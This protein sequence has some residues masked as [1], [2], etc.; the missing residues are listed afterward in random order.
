MT[1]MMTGIK[2]HTL[3]KS[4]IMAGLGLSL[5]FGAFSLSARQ[6]RAGDTQSNVE[7][8][9]GPQQD[10]QTQPRQGQRGNDQTM[11]EDQQQ[12]PETQAPP[13]QGPPP[14][15]LTLPA[16]TVIRMRLDEWLS[17]DRNVI[18]DDFGATLDQPIVVDGWVVARRGQSE[19]GRISLVKKAHGSGTSQLGLQ[20]S[21]LTLVDGQQLPVQVKLTQISGGNNSSRGE[22]VAI[23]GTTT[24]IGAAIGAVADGGTGAAIGAG[25]GAIGGL[26]GVGTRGKPTVV[27]PETVLSFRLEAPVT[28]STERSQSAF[29]PVSQ[30]DYNSRPGSGRPQHF[31]TSRGPGYPPP[32]PYYYGYPYAYGYPY[33]F[34]YY[35]APFGFGFYGG[36]GFGYGFGYGRGFGGFRGGF[37]R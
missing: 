3:S 25:I 26:I 8:Q 32:A 23:V 36:Y 13:N 12:G 9:Q 5:S 4:M 34:G 33:G 30:D 20:L 15:S 24:G 19:T 29:Q 37:R 2:N 28:I 31:E 18:G 21:D 10:S 22:G 11:M 14:A 35:P 16:G 7:Q 17:S 27:P 1:R 6:N